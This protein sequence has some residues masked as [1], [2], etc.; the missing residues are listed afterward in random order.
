[1]TARCSL[2]AIV[3]RHSGAC[4][5]IARSDRTHPLQVL[6][7]TPEE[8]VSNLSLRRLCTVFD[9]GEELRLD[10]DALEKAS[11]S[12]SSASSPCVRRR[13]RPIGREDPTI[14]ADIMM[15]RN[16]R[17]A[18]GGRS[19]AAGMSLVCVANFAI[20]SSGARSPAQ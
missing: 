1:M 13:R 9:L 2:A 12:Y 17:S 7:K 19:Q 18:E 10:P 5:P 4:S 16:F 8:R 20:A 6:P 15:L 11:S 14:T 3:G